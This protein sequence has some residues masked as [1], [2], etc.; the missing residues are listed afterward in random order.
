MRKTLSGTAL[1][2][3]SVIQYYLVTELLENEI[4]V[5]GVLVRFLGEIARIPAI[6]VSWERIQTLLNMLRKGSVTPVTL[7]DVVED[8]LIEF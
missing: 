3:N 1:C 7:R 5:Y 4:E 8:F 6:T 2:K